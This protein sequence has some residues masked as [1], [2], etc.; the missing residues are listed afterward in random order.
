[1]NFQARNS[2]SIFCQTLENKFYCLKVLP[3][4]IY[5]ISY[6]KG[7]CPQTQKLEPPPKT[8]H[9]HSSGMKRVTQSTN[10]SPQVGIALKS[11]KSESCI[12]VIATLA[13]ACR[14]HELLKYL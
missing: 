6:I 11:V 7:F 4:T 14:L 10:N 13:L 12:Q 3:K 5:L 8:P 9:I 2:F 1:M